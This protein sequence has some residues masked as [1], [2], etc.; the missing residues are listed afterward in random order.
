MTLWIALLEK[1]S[2][3]QESYSAIPLKGHWH[4]CHITPI[5]RFF[6]PPQWYIYLQRPVS[7][8]ITKYKK[9]KKDDHNPDIHKNA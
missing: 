1:C 6:S 5:L 2:C 7:K 8:N 3:G 9:K 4:L